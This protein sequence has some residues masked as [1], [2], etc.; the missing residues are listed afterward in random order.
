MRKYIAIVA[1]ILSLTLYSISGEAQ[2]KTDN[3]L[4][5]VLLKVFW[6]RLKQDVK[7]DNR[8]AVIKVFEFPIHAAHI[9]TFQYAYDCDTAAF[10]RNEKK[11]NNIDI[12]EKNIQAYYN[13]VF[14]AVLKE[15]ISKTTIKHLL[16]KG[17]IDKKHP[18]L[19]YHFF[20]GEYRK[21]KCRNDHQLTFHISQKDKTFKISIGGL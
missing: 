19:S 5:T 15:L 2:T 13:F 3:G 17:T 20:P 16:T 18:W 10:I 1:G 14:S 11:Y 7:T 8:A 9:V 4:D 6:N 12:T 21:V